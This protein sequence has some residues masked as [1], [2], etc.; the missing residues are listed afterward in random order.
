MTG[1]I[2]YDDLLAMAAAVHICIKLT[3][4]Q[5]Y[6]RSLPELL[7]AFAARLFVTAT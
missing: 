6:P 4:Q 5:R 3:P 7:T 1:T 2:E